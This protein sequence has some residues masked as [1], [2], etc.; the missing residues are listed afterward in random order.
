MYW[1]EPIWRKLGLDKRCIGCDGNVLKQWRLFATAAGVVG[2]L[3]ALL[4]ALIATGARRYYARR[5]A[6]VRAAPRHRAGWR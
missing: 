1:T 6:R 3:C 5:A 4:A 2:G